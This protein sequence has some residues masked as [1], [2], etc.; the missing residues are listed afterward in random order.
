VPAPKSALAAQPTTQT[1]QS[2]RVTQESPSDGAVGITSA[3]DLGSQAPGA[4]T[5]APL[6]LGGGPAGVPA[7]NIV[8]PARPARSAAVRAKRTRAETVSKTSPVKKKG[9]VVKRALA[10]EIDDGIEDQ[11][12][13]TQ[14]SPLKRVT[15]RLQSLRSREAPETADSNPTT[16]QTTLD[17]FPVLAPT[18]ERLGGLGGTKAV[19]RRRSPRRAA[20]K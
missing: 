8:L 20:K 13:L 7:N 14:H 19:Q 4:A 12:T 3:G 5:P 9:R 15:A 2:A 10:E 16:R 17:S 6:N 1:R 18:V 11:L